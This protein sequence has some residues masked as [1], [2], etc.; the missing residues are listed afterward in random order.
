MTP[1]QSRTARAMLHW[2]QEY[3]AEAADV[4]VP[5]VRRFENKSSTVAPH[6]VKKMIRAFEREGVVF[7]PSGGVDLNRER[8]I[9]L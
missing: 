4:S 5:T 9:N 2:R 7:L 1:D 6:T 3:L 8:T